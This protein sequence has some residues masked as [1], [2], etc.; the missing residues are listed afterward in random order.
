MNQKQ[1]SYRLYRR[2]MQQIYRFSVW[3]S[4]LNLFDIYFKSSGFFL[5]KRNNLVLEKSRKN[6]YE[7]N[8]AT[9][10]TNK[11]SFKIL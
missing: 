7:T 11:N 4:I 3:K 10:L 1:T 6:A 2:L 8:F 9:I 5:I